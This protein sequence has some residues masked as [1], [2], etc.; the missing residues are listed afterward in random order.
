MTMNRSMKAQQ[1]LLAWGDENLNEVP[2]WVN[3]PAIAR[4]E[5]VTRLSWLL[6]KTVSGET[7]GGEVKP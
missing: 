2:V 5:M 3:L 6:T 4:A 1:Q 7:R